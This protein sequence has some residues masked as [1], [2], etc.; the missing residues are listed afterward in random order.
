MATETSREIDALAHERLVTHLITRLTGAFPGALP[1]V[2]QT[3][4][5]SVI[6]AGEFAYKIKRPVR[7]S[8]LDFS[9]LALRHHFCQEELRIN[10]RLAP[11]LYLDVLPITGS[12][13]APVIDGPGEPVEYVLRMRRFE[14]DHEFRE[15]A[16]AGRLQSAH[17]E[18]LASYL[19][20]FHQGLAPLKPQAPGAAPD[21]DAWQWAAENLDEIAAHPLRPATCPLGDLGALRKTLEVLFARHAGLMA[22]RRADGFVRECHGDLHLGNIVVW[23][24]EVLAFDAIEFDA[25]LRCIDIVNDV[26]FTFM[27]LHAA[28]QRA[29]AWRLI[30][31][32]VE[33]T[34][35]FEG[36]ILLHGFAAYR[37]IVRA[38][39]ALLSGP[40]VAEFTAYWTLAQ[41][42]AGAP[43]RP[44]LVLTMGLSGS[45]K[46]AAAQF[47]AEELGAVCL[48]SDVERKRLHGLAPTARPVP[49]LAMYSTQ[50]TQRTYARLAD[51]AGQL[52]AGGLS[53]VMDA[54]LLRHEERDT[55][56]QLARRLGVAFALVECVAP[57][58]TLGRRIVS[59][60][61]AGT[62]PSDATLE[63]L[64]MQERV[65]EAVPV[66]W[67]PWHT[68][69]SND[70]SLGELREQVQA[71][72]SLWKDER[73]RQS[74]TF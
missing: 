46:S 24:G 65:R 3:H 25:V 11:Q 21:K 56:M 7:L 18:E 41:Q 61:T 12:V 45:G 13:E 53:V 57:H 69:L 6:L 32:W 5:S 67:A 62:D 52:L 31:A 59:R 23:H 55:L 43:S 68:A 29:L 15:L 58:A 42:L 49:A 30:N 17:V 27:D 50:A 66:D 36:L 63:V 9:T 8:F 20:R 47:I 26:A 74:D 1:H 34:G 48:R 33:G 19:A 35:D 4:I 39:V 51:L 22:R 64:E 40:K 14:T 60:A 10:R 71:L 44:R 54:A 73:T 38:K 72:V 37:A 2:V 16:R 28:G 70:G